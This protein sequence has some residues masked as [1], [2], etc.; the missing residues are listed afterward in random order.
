MKE[1]T[2]AKYILLAINDYKNLGREQFLKKF[3]LRK[4]TRQQFDYFIHFEGQSFECKPIFQAAYHY[5]FKEKLSKTSGVNKY[6]K[7]NLELLG[8]DV[9]ATDPFLSLPQICNAYYWVNIGTSFKEVA[10]YKFLWAPESTVNEKGN[11]VIDAGWKAVPN[12]RK[13]DVI[14][15]NYKGSIIHVAIAKSN[16]YASPRPENRSFVQWKESG[17]RVDIELVTLKTS[18]P[19]SEFKEDF[20]PLFNDYCQPKLFTKTYT[21]AQNYMVRLPNSAGGFLLDLI[22]EEAL[23]IHDGIA[24]SV[25]ANISEG[26]EREAIVKA[27]V[28][29]GVFREEVMKYWKDSCALTN[30]RYRQLLIASHILPWQHSNSVEKVDKF[31]GLALAPTA[32]KLFDKGL[33]SFDDNGQILIKEFLCADTL[34]KLGINNK[35]KIN[36][37]EK[38]HFKYLS[39]HRELFHFN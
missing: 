4:S 5:E 33:I 29:Q 22:G 31:N 35:M 10:E 18:I 28:G 38:E 1:V 25:G 14:F 8:F 37:L 15:C 26:S 27:R 32:D 16:A 13:G 39:R 3:G 12:I 34:I 19:N 36:G 6:I 17:Y 20:V 23:K 11:T 7:P 2:N 9:V 21:V 30:V 24:T